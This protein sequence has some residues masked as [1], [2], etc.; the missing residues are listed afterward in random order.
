MIFRLVFRIK[1]TFSKKICG[2]IPCEG[3][4]GHFLGLLWMSEER[5]IF[6]E[7]LFLTV[8]SYLP[9]WPWPPKDNWVSFQL[10]WPVLVGMSHQVQS[11]CPG[12]LNSPWHYLHPLRKRLSCS[13]ALMYPGKLWD[14]YQRILRTE[15]LKLWWHCKNKLFNSHV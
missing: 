15:N 2:R 6:S 13:R 8:L 14:F 7:I 1:Y 10:H 12:Y 4:K 9:Q 5:S 11:V 3:Q